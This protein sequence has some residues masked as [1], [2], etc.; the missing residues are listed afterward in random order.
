MKKVFFLILSLMILNSCSNETLVGINTNSSSNGALS[1]KI[2]K[3]SVPAEV[4][5]IVA[6]L[7]RANYDILRTSVYVSSDSSSE[8]SFTDVPIGEWHL[9][10][11]A[12]NSNGKVIYSGEADVT[13]IEDQTIDIYLTL[14][15][16]GGGKG[17]INIYINWNNQSMVWTDYSN[18]PVFTINDS[19]ASS[20][21][22][23]TSKIFYEEGVFNMWYL[24]TYA[25]GRG[26]VWYTKSDDGLNW[27][28]VSYQP[29]FA[30]RNIPAWDDYTVGP[31]AIL[32]ENNQYKMYYNGWN[33]QYGKWQIGFAVSNDGINWERYD[34]PVLY[35]DSSHEF[36]IG[37]SSV[38]K[39]DGVYFMYYTSNDIENYDKMR[40]NLATSSDGI[41][42]KKFTN[43]PILSPTE[44]WEGIGVNFPAV[45]YDNGR[46]VM[47]YNNS[48]RTKFGIAF[49]QDGYNW[50]KSPQYTFGIENTYNH[51]THINYPFF[52]K[53]G[54]EY[55]IY[56]S[57]TTQDVILNI[58]FAYTFKLE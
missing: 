48:E 32:K 51:Y 23:S 30:G 21:Y 24:S 8:L 6:E 7:S 2:Q 20:I 28:S 26:N 16:V 29:V 36:K 44:N 39:I 11:N 57:G 50:T 47:I 58:N 35:A 38:L 46:F 1:L 54:N 37:V 31:G 18:N 27:Q 19:P 42:W 34:N 52:I 22:V 53:I 25:A 41:D 10:V 43:N 17:K 5:Q 33:N 3:T 49:S 55:R 40:I 45:I 9:K 12:Q 56:Y 13:V 4:Y 14:T 15:P